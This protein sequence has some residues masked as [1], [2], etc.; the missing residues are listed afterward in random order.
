MSAYRGVYSIARGYRSA[1]VYLGTAKTGQ[2]GG[3]VTCRPDK[4]MSRRERYDVLAEFLARDSRAKLTPPPYRPT[5][6]EKGGTK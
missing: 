6:R 2:I 1:T 5:K 4:G 3:R